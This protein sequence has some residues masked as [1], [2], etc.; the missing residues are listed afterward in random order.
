MIKKNKNIEEMFEELTRRMDKITIDLYTS[1][2]EIALDKIKEH[3]KRLDG[4]IRHLA[5]ND[6][7]F[8][9]LRDSVFSLQKTIYPK[10]DSDDFLEMKNE[11]E[12]ILNTRK[13]GVE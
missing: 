5:M 3:E 10:I 12:S 13:S 7:E 11:L 6:N 2:S 1:D 8:R 9:I 4:I